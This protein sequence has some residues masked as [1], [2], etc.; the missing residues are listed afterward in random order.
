MAE[1][2]TARERARIEITATIK[3]IAGRHLA[4]HG[5]SA[6]SLRAVA[7][8]MELSSSAVYRYFAS[9]DELLTA[10]IIDAYDS[11]GEAVELAEAAAPRDAFARRWAAAAR[12]IRSWALARPHEYA[13]I[14][15]SPVP[16]Y[17]APTDTIGPATRTARVL[18]AIVADAS[19]AGALHPLPTG[20]PP[21]AAVS[22]DLETMAEFFGDAPEAVRLRSLRGWS[23]VFGLVSFEL[24]GQ[25]TNVLEH[26]SDFFDHTVTE[27]GIEIG[28][29]TPEDQ[30]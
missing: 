19:T 18:G 6:L 12:A 24:F 30:P 1:P 28:L 9:R 10:L 11:L 15:G 2:R 22:A 27:L 7:R 5:A 17:R 29:G 20:A 16:G 4:E 25:F 13:L 26:P 21:S 23:T 14:Y 3:Q 8:E